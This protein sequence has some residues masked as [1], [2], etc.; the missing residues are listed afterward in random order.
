[1]L[2][3]YEKEIITI[4]HAAVHALEEIQDKHDARQ[5]RNLLD[6]AVCDF[7]AHDFLK[8]LEAKA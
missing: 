3:D 4:L 6:R 7:K 1:M 8:G 5:V 2:N